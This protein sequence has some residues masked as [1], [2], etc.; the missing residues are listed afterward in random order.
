MPTAGTCSAASGRAA[1]TCGCNA[2]GRR[3]RIGSSF[4]VR[5][6]WP[7][8]ASPGWIPAGLSRCGSP[9]SALAL[10]RF[11]CS[12]ASGRSRS[13]SSRRRCGRRQ[14]PRQGNEAMRTQQDTPSSWRFPAYTGWKSSTAP[15]ASA[16]RRRS[17][18][19][20][21]R[22]RCRRS[23]LRYRPG[24]S[25]ASWRWTAAR[26]RAAPFPLAVSS[27]PRGAPARF[28]SFRSDAA[29]RNRAGCWG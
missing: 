20:R 28:S 27:T 11:A 12:T 10:A 15:A 9:A 18:S 13:R 3:S 1:T 16:C 21:G 14:R 5:T 17:G 6:T 24:P 2:W 7:T 26:W 29:A 22:P 4:W 8:R 25:V 23:T 19:K